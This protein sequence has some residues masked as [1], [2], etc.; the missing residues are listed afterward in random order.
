[1][2]AVQDDNGKVYHVFSGSY[3][4]YSLGIDG[5][6][7]NRTN[8]AGNIKSKNFDTIEIENSVK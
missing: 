2:A 8:M 4:R 6:E 1:M 3:R 5:K 7:K